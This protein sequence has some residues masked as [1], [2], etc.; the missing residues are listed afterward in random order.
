M[1]NCATNLNYRTL[2]SATSE[3]LV[4][5]Q[6]KSESVQNALSELIADGGIG[7]SKY[8]TDL[9]SLDYLT[10]SLTALSEFWEGLALGTPED[11]SLNTQE[12]ANKV[13]LKSLSDRLC[14]VKERSLNL[15]EIETGSC[16]LF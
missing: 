9:Q 4:K 10:Q 16:D 1:E 15:T 13:K 14:G 7:H 11:W 12:L 6:R 3:E 8:I 2:A 5:L